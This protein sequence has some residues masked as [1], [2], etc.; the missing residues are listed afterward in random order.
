MSCETTNDVFMIV[1]NIIILAAAV[2]DA[3]EGAD[4]V[5]EAFCEE[6]AMELKA[7]FAIGNKLAGVIAFEKE[8]IGVGDQMLE[9]DGWLEFTDLDLKLG[10]VVRVDNSVLQQR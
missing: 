3:V 8:Q 6:F 2:E 7:H 1:G 10:P 9:A 4:G 5:A